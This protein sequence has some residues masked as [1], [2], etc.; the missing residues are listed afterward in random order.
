MG[1]FD[2]IKCEVALPETGQ[3]PPALFQT[4]DTPD[5]Y[6]TVYTITA[7]G[8]LT[9]KPYHME[10][11]PKNERPYPDKDGILGLR[12]SMR[13]VEC[14]A[15]DIDFHGDIFFYASGPRDSGWW[16]YRA[17]FTEGKLSNIE[18]VEFTPA[19]EADNANG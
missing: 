5:Q 14:D 10:S 1:M 16:E 6:M 19:K 9:W 2:Y 18:L 13:R 12:G 7:D 4:K 17:R 15:E 8:R 3:A 11:V